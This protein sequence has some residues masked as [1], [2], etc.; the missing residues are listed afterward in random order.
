MRKTR[1]FFIL[2]FVC[3][4]ALPLLA[5][6]KPGTVAVV[7][8]V[9]AKAGMRQQFEQAHKR[10]MGWHRQQNDTWAINVWEVVN[11]E[12]LGQYEYGW[13]GHHWKDF[14]SRAKF[15]EADDADY[16]AN[17]GPYVEPIAARYYLYHPELSRPM[18][19][20][21]PLAEV[22]VFHL[23]VGG[24]SD[25]LMAVRKSHEA[26]QKSNY[27][28]YY[29]VYELYNGGEHP[30]YVFA[31]PHKNWAD[32]EPPEQT[33]RA[34]LE[35]VYGHDEAESILK[36]WDK[37]VHSERSEIIAFRPDLSYVPAAK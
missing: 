12:R 3:L 13:F 34:M 35:K 36:L 6:E 4:L 29:H 24:E 8:T 20:E 9:K 7:F 16:Y 30:T 18:E 28:V 32:F 14:D 22:V 10:H 11:G 25:F 27:P 2:G 23:N 1:F 33:F 26:I 5:Q 17:V 15:E 37:S 21:A 19:G 31:F